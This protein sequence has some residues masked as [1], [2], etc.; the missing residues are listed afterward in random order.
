MGL[1][2][3]RVQFA[4]GAVHPTKQSAVA[5]VHHQYLPQFSGL[6]QKRGLFHLRSKL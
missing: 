2:A 4:L 3:G 1:A 6:A 5:M